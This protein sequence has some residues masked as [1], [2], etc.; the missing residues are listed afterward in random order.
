[1]QVVDFKSS[2]EVH[3]FHSLL[4]SLQKFP[5]FSFLKQLPANTERKWRFEMQWKF[6][7]QEVKV[8]L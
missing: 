4:R 3:L 7:D 8:Y 2:L 6:F 5:S 1:M